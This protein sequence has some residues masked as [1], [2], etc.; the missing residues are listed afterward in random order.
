MQYGKDYY[1]LQYRTEWTNTDNVVISLYENGNTMQAGI[2][3]VTVFKTGD[4]RG[5]AYLWNLHVTEDCRG[6]GYGR[7]LLS[8]AYDV[9]MLAD[10]DRI[11]LDWE[12]KDSPY[13]VFDWY[14][15]EGFDE[16]E[17]GRGCAFMVKPVKENEKKEDA[18]DRE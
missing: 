5:E 3:E 11:T 12:L 17:F 2:V 15:R 9:A 13:W 14:V 16:R 10:C 1:T 18:N 8:E 6:R 4:R 7:A